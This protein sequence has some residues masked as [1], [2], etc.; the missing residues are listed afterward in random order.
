MTVVAVAANVASTTD[1]A[2]AADV[3]QASLFLAQTLTP[4]PQ[5]L[6]I[7]QTCSQTEFK[8]NSG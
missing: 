7:F 8:L 5:I 3:K 6:V 1:E 4:Q 2:Q